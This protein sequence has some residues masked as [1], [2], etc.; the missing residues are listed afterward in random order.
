[1]WEEGTALL[2]F[3]LKQLMNKNCLEVKPQALCIIQEE[4]AE[5]S[6]RGEERAGWLSKHC[7]SE[8]APY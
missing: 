4:G 8:T 5:V 7:L 1:M 2:A 3:T 6:S